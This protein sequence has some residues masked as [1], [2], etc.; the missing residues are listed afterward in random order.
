MREREVGRHLVAGSSSML[1]ILAPRHAEELTVHYYWTTCMETWGFF[2]SI[3]RLQFL[4]LLDLS[5]WFIKNLREK[6][7][8]LKYISKL[9]LFHFHHHLS[10][11]L[12][13]LESCSSFLPERWRYQQNFVGESLY[14]VRQTEKQN[15]TRPLGICV[16]LNMPFNFSD[17]SKLNK[18]LAQCLVPD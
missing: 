5:L 14:G 7:G 11:D 2:L 15:L 18:H 1:R 17:F 13:H 9:S 12:Y 16:I 6:P 4:L 3:D 10:P 8:Y